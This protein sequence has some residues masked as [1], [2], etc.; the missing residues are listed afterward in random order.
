MNVVSTKLIR[1]LAM[2]K[3]TLDSSKTNIVSVGR[4]DSV[5]GFDMAIEACA[6]IKKS[7]PNINWHIIGEGIERAN[8]QAK[9]DAL[10][11]KK[12]FFLLG[13]K[14]NPYPYMNA[15]TVYAQTSLH[16]GRSSTI[17]EAK[18]LNKAIV[19]T[20]FDSIFEQIQNEVNGVIVEKNPPAI[21]K[22]ILELIN[23]QQKSQRFSI[24]LSTE[25]LGTE[26]E[27]QKFYELLKA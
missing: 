10:D 3:S 20:N 19:A 24:A 17:N 2:E 12:E 7:H 14:Q 8:L 18:I 4:L 27:I 11:L 26:E 6:I 9:I 16:E 21:A 25:K 13:E 22:A 1:D 15:A 5:K 23:D